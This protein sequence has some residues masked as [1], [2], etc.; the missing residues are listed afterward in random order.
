MEEMRASDPKCFTRGQ[1][2]WRYSDTGIA[3]LL[4]FLIWFL[5]DLS[6]LR[7]SLCPYVSIL[8]LVRC[9]FSSFLS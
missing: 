2:S 1:L 7:L 5:F 3:A 6:Y 8:V 9:I 4:N